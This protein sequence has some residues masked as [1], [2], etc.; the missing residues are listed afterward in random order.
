M[1]GCK[2]WMWR[3]AWCAAALW[4]GHAEAAAQRVCVYDMLGTGG[5]LYSVSRDYAISMQKVGA[6][7]E[8]KGYTDERVATEDFRTGQCDGLIATGLRVR[9][10]NP[11]TGTIDSL[12]ATTIVR[13]GKIDVP[14]SYEVV[15][16]LIQ[17]YAS[18]KAQPLMVNDIYEIGGILPLGAAYPFLNDR[19]LNTVESLAGKRITALDFDKAQAAMIQRVGAQPVAADITTFAPKFN[20]GMADMVGAPAMAYKPL[21][22]YKGIGK[23]GGITRFPLLILT[24]QVVFN[25][26]RFPA[27]FGDYSRDY[28][29]RHFDGALALIANAENAIPRHLWI[30]LPADNAVKYTLMLRQARVDIAEQGLY[31]KRALR[32]MKK[33]RCSIN[34]S[35]SECSTQAEYEWKTP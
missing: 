14:A 15:R 5:D 22:L 16:R 25:R 31:N 26:T 8:L 27:G 10:F 33:V 24:Y 28:W 21:E 18:P 13:D 6:N 2:T 12:G 19:H 29:L 17:T 9:Q 4:A 34:P 32:I 30:D 11:I 3:A 1:R 20:N 35:D 23:N 7:I